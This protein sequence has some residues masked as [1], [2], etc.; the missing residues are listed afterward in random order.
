MVETVND[1]QLAEAALSPQKK[2]LE[3]YKTMV[4]PMGGI[5][6]NYY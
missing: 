5:N 1:E 2:G 3:K 4:L 6:N